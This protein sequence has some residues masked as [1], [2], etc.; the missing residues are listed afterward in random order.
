MPPWFA[1]LPEEARRAILGGN[2]EDVPDRYRPM[3]ERFRKWLAE[4][5]G[6]RTR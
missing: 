3:L 2:A 5:A 1:E 6:E 4:H